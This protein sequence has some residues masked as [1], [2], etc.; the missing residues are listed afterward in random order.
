MTPER[1]KK[2]PA[3]PSSMYNLEGVINGLTVNAK[4]DDFILKISFSLSDNEIVQITDCRYDPEE[5]PQIF[6]VLNIRFIED[7]GDT[8][9]TT[10]YLLNPDLKS[11]KKFEGTNIRTAKE[12]VEMLE[13]KDDPW[14]ELGVLG[15][16]EF[17][18]KYPE[19]DKELTVAKAFYE[20]EEQLGIHF[21]SE[22]EIQKLI[23]R[24]S[25]I[26]PESQIPF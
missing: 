2:V 3:T 9:K 10:D 18:E 16:D 13:E 25:L 24:L 11:I 12:P 22:T 21:V 23:M 14:E 6:Q 7:L 5:S 4:L 20:L 19:I 1:L 26:N 17:L 8:T 15:W